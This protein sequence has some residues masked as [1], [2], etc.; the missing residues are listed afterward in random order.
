MS[1]ESAPPSKSAQPVSQTVGPLIDRSR[2]ATVAR[3]A[4]EL[5]KLVSIPTRV[6]WLEDRGTRFA[7]RLTTQL[8][9]K[10][11]ATTSGSA[12][13][14]AAQPS[15]RFNPFLPYDEDLFVGALG[16]KH[17][18]LLNKFNVVDDHLLIVTREFESQLSPLTAG[19]FA[20]LL[21]AWRGFPGLAFYNG[22]PAAGASQPHKHLQL[23][24]WERPLEGPSLPLDDWLV[25]SGDQVRGWNFTHAIAR[26][27][28]AARGSGGVLDSSS[29][30]QI[31]A[32]QLESL[33]WELLAR[34][35]L[36][37]ASPHDAVPPYNLLALPGVMVVIRRLCECF[38]DIS[39]NAMAFA[40]GL[41]VKDERQLELL[42][43]HGPWSALEAVTETAVGSAANRP[44]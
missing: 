3:R 28:H 1:K 5:G 14:D 22:G 10:A 16:P 36:A 13:G 26:W 24:P 27:P 23:I 9:R 21:E 31:T 12:T 42:R 8:A 4:T 40:G 44:T 41:L 20:A 18:A 25:G 2:V 37:P 19:D 35:G 6:E 32:S 17:V 33:Y 34:C 29:I 38:H 39:L 15:A 11:A 43:H 7:V 30:S